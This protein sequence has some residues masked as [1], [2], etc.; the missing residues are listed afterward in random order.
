MSWPKDQ[1][2]SVGDDPEF[3]LPDEGGDFRLVNTDEP[4]C[5]ACYNPPYCAVCGRDDAYFDEDYSQEMSG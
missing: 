2:E 3:Y 5:P 1:I 4:Y